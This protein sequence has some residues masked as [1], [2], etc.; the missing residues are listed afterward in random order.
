MRRFG[1]ERERFG[2]EVGEE[3]VH[4]REGREKNG[5]LLERVEQ[6]KWL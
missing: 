3:K 5:A 1:E 6:R 4:R 2:G